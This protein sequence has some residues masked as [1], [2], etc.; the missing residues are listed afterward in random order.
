MCRG[1]QSY[2][3]LTPAPVTVLKI[4]AC[5][6]WMSEEFFPWGALGDFSK[7]LLVGPK[8]GEICSFPLNT[9]ETTFLAEIFKTQMLRISL[10]ILTLKT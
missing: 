4:D 7:N 6:A 9:K 5:S 1:N 2:L 8:S 3:F 10:K